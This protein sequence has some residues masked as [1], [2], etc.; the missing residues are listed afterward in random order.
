[1][2]SSGFGIGVDV[3]I[4][5]GVDVCVGVKIGAGVRVWV[6]EA[7]GDESSGVEFIPE[8]AE[9]TIIVAHT[10]LINF[11]LVIH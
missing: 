5:V 7:V 6:D 8:H 10:K 9:R 11:V 1:M 2:I 3:G 4:A